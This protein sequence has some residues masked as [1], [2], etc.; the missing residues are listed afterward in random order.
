MPGPVLVATWP[1]A[2]T[3]V[4][5]AWPALDRGGAALDAVCAVCRHVEEDPTVDSV[6]YGGLPDMDG[7]VTLDALVMESPTR[8][9]AVCA[10]GRHREAV[11]V[12]RR[13]LE[14]SPHVL[15]AG[16][17][18]DR[19]ADEQGVP[20]SPLLAPAARA[21]W[22]ERDGG[23]GTASHDTICALSLD[24]EGRLAGAASTSGAAW[25]RPGRVGDSPLPGHG[26]YVLPGV[27][28][29]AATGLGELVMGTCSTFVAVD[30]LRRG[31]TPEEAL[32][33]ALGAV[34]AARPEGSTD[35]V[36]LVALGVDGRWA[37]AALEPGFEAVAR[38]A[39][40]ARPTG[41]G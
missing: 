27:G 25:K 8:L 36:A 21:R 20:A 12:A 9:G 18:A 6:G 28:A 4:E 11:T 26:L 13:V 39:T 31:A 33:V 3:A 32:G 30:E 35:Q 1:F 41:P 22:E 17:G 19:F 24:R 34:E 14:A 2:A 15:L 16:E 5:A 7:R 40:P 37:S 23:P 29:A 38:W 10:M